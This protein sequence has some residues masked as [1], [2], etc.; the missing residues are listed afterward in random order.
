MKRIAVIFALA[1]VAAVAISCSKK[2][3]TT[4]DMGATSTPPAGTQ[5]KPSAAAMAK[6]ASPTAPASAAKETSAGSGSL[7][8]STANSATDTDDSWVEMVDIDGDGDEEQV[9]WVWDDEDKI[10]YGYTEDDEAVGDGVVVAAELW[11]FYGT[12]NA[13][14]APV[15]SGWY[16][17]GVGEA[18]ST[19]AYANLWG[20][21][22]DA[23]GNATQCG[24][25]TI[26]ATNDAIVI[27]AATTQ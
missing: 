17:E 1:L 6:A 4:G 15:G 7:S 5:Q 18:D 16:V 10:L 20:C 3:E 27:T 8:A 12:G 19:Q 26:D 25:C 11:A 9:D 2:T 22:F 21:S 24:A 14:G 23:S 13:M